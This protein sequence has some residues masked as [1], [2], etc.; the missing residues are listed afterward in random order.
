MKILIVLAMLMAGCSSDPT[1]TYPSRWVSRYSD[2]DYQ[3]TCWYVGAANGG[4][5][6][7][8]NAEVEDR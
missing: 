3:V 5:S 1:V 4:I 7:L 6:C 8:P 2:P